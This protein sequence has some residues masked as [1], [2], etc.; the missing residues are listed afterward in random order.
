MNLTINLEQK[1]IEQG[2][3]AKELLVNY[4]EEDYYYA[5]FKFSTYQETYVG[6]DNYLDYELIETNYMVAISWNESNVWTRM[7]NFQSSYASRVFA[8]EDI[9]DLDIAMIRNAL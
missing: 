7:A 9:I 1:A 4:D 5:A 2:Y 3:Y 8:E 6:G